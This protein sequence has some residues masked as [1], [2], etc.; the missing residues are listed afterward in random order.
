MWWRDG[1]TVLWGGRRH[2]ARDMSFCVVVPEAGKPLQSIPGMLLQLK[3]FL[4]V[5]L[6]R[7]VSNKR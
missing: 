6:A 7:Q 4:S 3:T 5:L 2:R 1:V